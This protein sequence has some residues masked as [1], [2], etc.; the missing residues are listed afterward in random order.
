MNWPVPRERLSSLQAL[1]LD[2]DGVLTPGSL[3]YD[4]TGKRLLSF[5]ARDGA[6]ISLLARS[7]FPIAILS[8]RPVDIAWHRHRELGVR[9]FISDCQEKR[10]GLIDLAHKLKVDYAHCAFV[11]DDLPDLAAFSVAGL[12]IAV[13]DAAYEVRERA[14][15]ITERTGGCGAVREVCETILK[16]QGKWQAILD[17]LNT[18]HV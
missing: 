17:A 4:E 10:Q 13:A 1:I 7:G 12:C 18:T 11:G 9:Y 16:A 8:G 15:W 6:G 2:C 3:I 14:D 5:S